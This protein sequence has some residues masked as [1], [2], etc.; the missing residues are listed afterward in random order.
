MNSVF[1]LLTHPATSDCSVKK[2]IVFAKKIVVTVS[3]EM[4]TKND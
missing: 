2:S 1:E 4:I 3:K